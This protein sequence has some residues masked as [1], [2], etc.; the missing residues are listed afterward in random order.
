MG[1]TNCGLSDFHV[2][3]AARQIIVFR[4]IEEKNYAMKFDILLKAI[5]YFDAVMRNGSAT[6]A[7]EQLFVTPGAVAQQI[8]KLEASLGVTLFTRAI[9]KLHPTQVAFSYWEQVRPALLQLDTASLTLRNRTNDEIR[10]SLPP[11]LANSWF[12]RRIPALTRDDPQLKLHLNASTDLLDG[13][14]DTFDI[15]VRHCDGHAPGLTAE[16]LL[17]GEVMVY[18]SPSYRSALRLFEVSDLVKAT[19]LYTTSHA[20]WPKWFAHAGLPH[21][22][23]KIGMRFD[24]SELAIDAAR[25]SQ[26]VVLTSPWLVEDALEQNQLVQLFDTS[27]SVGKDYYLVH[28]QNAPLH[29]SADRLRQWLLKTSHL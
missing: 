8:R 27:L 24:Q 7:A 2:V 21:T 1:N 20:N 13:E 6:V 18:C 9:R 4:C 26:G 19:L 11:A 23:L 28:R 22:D 12:A 25:R 17:P 29:E 10:V 15:A 14:Q 5:V 16:L 3:K